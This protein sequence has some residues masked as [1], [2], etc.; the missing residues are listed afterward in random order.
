MKLR[1]KFRA[2]DLHR[3]LIVGIFKRIYC[4]DVFLMVLTSTEQLFI[5]KTFYRR[6]LHTVRHNDPVTPVKKFICNFNGFTIFHVSEAATGGVLLEKAFLEISQ[7]S[8]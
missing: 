6:F 3:T 7:N 5:R 8:Q 4:F 1:L 2:E